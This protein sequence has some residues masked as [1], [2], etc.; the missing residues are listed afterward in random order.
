MEGNGTWGVAIINPE[1][2]KAFANTTNP[3]AHKSRDKHR[4]MRVAA[5]EARIV[6]RES[7]RNGRDRPHYTKK[8]A[9][10]RDLKP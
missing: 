3:S 9:A 2:G 1:T 8:A 10:M 6:A 4:R 5:V 7:Q